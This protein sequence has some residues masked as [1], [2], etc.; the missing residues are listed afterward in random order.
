MQVYCLPI[1]EPFMNKTDLQLRNFVS[2]QRQE[3]MMRY[4]NEID[5]KLSLYAALV[6]RMGI[7]KLSGIPASEL[8]FHSQPNHKPYLISDASYCFSFSHTRNFVLSCI[9]TSIPVGADV[10]L[11]QEAPLEIMDLVFHPDEIQFITSNMNN[12]RISFYKVWTQKEA[13]TK[14]LGTGLIGNL[15]SINTMELLPYFHTWEQNGYM[16]CVFCS[17]KA[18]PKITTITTNDISAYYGID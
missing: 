13:Y 12:T 4:R 3:K 1:T 6:T 14:S 18:D 17:H 9:N 10:E 5:Q 2:F 11:I 7:S 15:T 8:L 16:C